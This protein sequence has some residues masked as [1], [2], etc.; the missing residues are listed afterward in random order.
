[1][2]CEKVRPEEIFVGQMIAPEVDIVRIDLPDSHAVGFQ[3]LVKS[4][5]K[6]FVTTLT[7]PYSNWMILIRPCAEQLAESSQY[8]ILHSLHVDLQEIDSLDPCASQNRSPVVTGA[9]RHWVSR[10]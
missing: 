7:Y 8:P 2:D 1:M 5:S 3:E 4:F 10:P 9:R 6:N